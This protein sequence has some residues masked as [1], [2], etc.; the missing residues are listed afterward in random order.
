MDDRCRVCFLVCAVRCETKDRGGRVY[1]RLGVCCG[2]FSWGVESAVVTNCGLPYM[3]KGHLMLA[4]RG[5]LD[6]RENHGGR[7]LI[8]AEEVGYAYGDGCRV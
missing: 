8:G 7:L 6:D 4:I 1:M 3:G 2:G 5:V